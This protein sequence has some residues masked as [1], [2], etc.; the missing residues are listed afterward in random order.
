[1]LGEYEVPGI[2][3][4]GTAQARALVEIHV[5]GLDGSY[6]QDLGSRAA[7][8]V[9]EGTLAGDD[10]RDGFLASARAALDAGDPVD[11]VADILTATAV[12]KVHVADLR[13]AE[14][15]GAADSFRYTLSLTQHTDP[16]PEPD[17]GLGDLADAI[18][19]EAGSLFDALQ[20]PDL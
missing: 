8:I 20:V 4:I 11:F 10:P 9:I 7:T 15:A 13:V 17:A 5:P 6:H 14:V 18:D 3:R 2:Q 12:E 19:A 16:P 1:M